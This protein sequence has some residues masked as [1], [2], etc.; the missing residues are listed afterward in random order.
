MPR[1]GKIS[2][3]IVED[4]ANVRFLLEAA[5]RRAELFDPIVVEN[6]GQAAWERLQSTE[7]LDLPGLIATDLSM[8]HMTGLELLKAV[9]NDERLRHIPV[10]VITSSDLPKDRDLALASGAC[11]FVHKPYG[12][13]ALVRALLGIRESCGEAAGTANAV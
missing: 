13:D 5:A 2:L 3:L 6:D 7:G 11:S 9:K 12:I 10:A 4:D 8:P 1:F